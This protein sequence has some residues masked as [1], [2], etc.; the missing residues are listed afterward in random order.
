M[1]NP[2]TK[3]EASRNGYV[4]DEDLDAVNEFN[5]SVRD[6][7]ARIVF[8]ALPEPYIGNPDLAKVV[9]LGLNPGYSV[10]DPEWHARKDFRGALLLNLNHEPTDYP[11]YPLDPAFRQSGAGQ[12]WR[13]RT[14]QLQSESGL[15]DRTFAKRIMVIEWFPYH[16]V[17]F[18][19]PKA[20]FH[21]QRYSFQLARE[22]LG[23]KV[24]VREA[25]QPGTGWETGL[26]RL[27]QNGSARAEF[28]ELCDALL[29]LVK[30][31]TD[32]RPAMDDCPLFLH[33][34]YQREE[35]LVALGL[36]NSVGAFHT[37]TG[38]F[39]IEAL[40][41]EVLFVTLDKS[42]KTF[43]PSTRYEDFALSPTR[44]HWQSQSTTGENSPTGRRY[45]RQRENGARFLLF[46]RPKKG[47]AFMFLGPL[48]YVSHSGSRPMSIYWD[49]DHPMPAWFFEICASLRAA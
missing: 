9:F 30:L 10:T 20:E 4:L 21:S 31:H 27:Q 3:L 17:S 46:V 29:D 25:R 11:F 47:D 38:R 24:L 37:Q 12:W 48:R 18:K 26:T 6:T 44:F 8:D 41:T 23:R 33:R 14:R 2:W 49:L 28:H 35:V 45:A 1:N 43:S 15:D 7:K 39:W 32:E 13:E 22:M 5:R 34:Q 16:S 40:Q 19:A 42:E 36:P